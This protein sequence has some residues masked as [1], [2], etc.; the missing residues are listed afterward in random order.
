MGFPFWKVQEA[1]A[2]LSSVK[3]LTLNVEKV[4]A[5]FC[6]PILQY[7]LSGPKIGCKRNPAYFLFSLNWLGFFFPRTFWGK[8]YC[9][10]SGL[11][12]QWMLKETANQGLTCFILCVNIIQSG[13]Q[14]GKGRGRHSLVTELT[15]KEGSCMGSCLLSLIQH[16]R[17]YQGCCVTFMSIL[18]REEVSKQDC[19]EGPF[20]S[21]IP[22]LPKTK[23]ERL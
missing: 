6:N 15:W 13:Q 3:G 22:S 2:Q 9:G 12:G 8:K 17:R 11:R 23:L 21:L 10:G 5:S 18:H 1:G 14:K 4:S 16:Q 7:H 19:R 20:L